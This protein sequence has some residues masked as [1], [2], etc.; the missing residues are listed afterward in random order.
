MNDFHPDLRKVARFL[1]K[2][3][4][5]PLLRRITNFLTRFRGVP[6]PPVVK[7]VVIRDVYIT[8]LD[9]SSSLRVRLYSPETTSAAVPA[10]LWMHSGGFMTGSSETGE[11]FNVE[12]AQALGIVV[13][14]VDYRLAPDFP[15]PTP[16]DDCYAA[17]TW[18]HTEAAALGILP[19]KIAVGGGQCR[20]RA[21]RRAGPIGT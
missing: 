19:D 10:L 5:N 16:L 8:G 12:R 1:P 13:A 2:F 21:G 7:G 6:K 17:L 15:F 9:G 18:L 4:V 14:S 3:T 20:W 11:Q